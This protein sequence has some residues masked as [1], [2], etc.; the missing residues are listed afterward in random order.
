M[1]KD[2][3]IYQDENYNQALIRYRDRL[4]KYDFSPEALGWRSGTQD[5]RFQAFMKGFT[6]IPSSIL[7][8]GCGFGDLL[9]FL[10][11]HG[12]DGTYLGIDLIPEFIDHAHSKFIK[13]NASDV[14]FICCDFMELNELKKFDATFASGIFNHLR[15][16]DNNSH[17]ERVLKKLQNITNQYTALDF[18]ST[19]SDRRSPDLYFFDPANVLKSA[20][21]YTKKIS[22]DHSYMPF[23]FMLKM[24]WN[25]KFRD[26]WPVF[27]CEVSHG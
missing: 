18:L 23:E 11:S 1:S 26:Q 6:Q 25:D 14:Q 9:Q 2:E 21:Q 24:Y 16:D 10:R 17:F 13:P 8:I 5:V 4:S 20:L 3:I 22:I 15:N 19:T 27:E 12:W 7:D